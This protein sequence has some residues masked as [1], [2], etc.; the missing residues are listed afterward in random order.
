M[1]M[2]EELIAEKAAERII[3]TAG[4]TFAMACLPPQTHL[5]EARQALKDAIVREIMAALRPAPK[6]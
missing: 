2:R 4:L 5:S 1:V 6:P 3:R